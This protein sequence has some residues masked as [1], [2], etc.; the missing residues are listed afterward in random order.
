MIETMTDVEA[1]LARTTDYEKMDRYAYRSFEAGLD[2]VRAILDRIE[3]P[4][5]PAPT[6]HIGGTNGKG[7]VAFFC[8]RLLHASG[9]TTGRFT[10]PHLE[11]LNERICLNGIPISDEALAAVFNQLAPLETDEAFLKAYGT[12]TFFEWITAAALTAFHNAEVDAILL[13]VGLGGR[14]DSTNI[15]DPAITVITAIQHDHLDKLGP[16]LEDVA[17]EKAGIIKPG[18]PLLTGE[19]DDRLF[20]VLDDRAAEVGAPV[21]RMV[22]PEGTRID[23]LRSPSRCM[24][25][26]VALSIAAVEAFLSQHDRELSGE[27][28]AEALSAATP[29]ARLEPVRSNVFLDC[30]HTE[31]AIRDALASLETIPH[32]R[33][34]VLFGALRDKDHAA[35]LAPI[36]ERA[37]RVVLTR[38]P[39]PR[40]ADPERMAEALEADVEVIPVPAEALDSILAEL[41]ES[42]LCLITGSV[43]LAG[44]L[45]HLLVVDHNETL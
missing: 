41:R 44:A 19:P 23:G 33:L 26:N 39:S 10:S 37:D 21:L 20:A 28:V 16:T 9:F 29:P 25:Q 6:I 36:C 17:M 27:V 11:R 24:Q 40:G 35:L 15:I 1:F 7:S 18:V 5:T 14:F 2:R 13:E 38:A 34:V 31:E 32:D 30:G 3:V 42:E 43:Y 22:L 4:D 12:P 45:R 8:D